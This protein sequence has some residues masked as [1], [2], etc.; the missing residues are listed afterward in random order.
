MIVPKVSPVPGSLSG[1]KVA[2]LAALIA[3]ARSCELPDEERH[4]TT[5]PVRL[6]RTVT[7]IVPLAL[8]RRAA[9]G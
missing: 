2:F 5:L 7:M 9:A 6:T 4:E 3:A 1:E 8:A